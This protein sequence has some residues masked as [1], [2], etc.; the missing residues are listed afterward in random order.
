MRGIMWPMWHPLFDLSLLKRHWF[1]VL[2]SA[3]LCFTGLFA[4]WASSLR[5]PDLGSFEERRVENS[6]KIYDRTGK[7]LLYDVHQNIK[8]TVIPFAEMGDNVK[9]ATVAIE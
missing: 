9:H 4:L 5:I 1:L 6:T 8:R 2:I 7:V 3:A